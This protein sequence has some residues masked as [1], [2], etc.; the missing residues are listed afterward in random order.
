MRILFIG[1]V[2][3]RSG[4]EALE[5]YLPGLRRRYDV[6]VVIVNAENAAHGR[7]PTAK[8]CKELFSLGVDCITGG[9]H[10]WDQR[11]ILSYIHGEKRLLRPLNFP[12][13]SPGQGSYH[14]RLADG[15]TVLIV[16]VVG[17]YGMKPV[18]DPF[19]AA[20][21]LSRANPLGGAIH[22]LFVD[23][24]MEMTSEKTAFGHFM[25]GKASAVL[26]SHT[27][28]PTADARIL[29]GGTAYQSDVGMTGDYDSVIG[30][31]KEEPIQRFTRHMTLG[32]FVPAE[33][34]GTLC[35]A[36]VET[37]DRTGRARAIVPVREGGVL[38]ESL[39][40]L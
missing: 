2:M 37:D 29:P 23:A 38:S 12:K 21:A 15:R 24:H 9:D 14:H 22:A 3:G 35:G 28:V 19:A 10:I 20:E 39:P 1:D 5:A 30:S 18:D 16:H 32:H 6:D 4:R 11:E 13:D 7:G 8:I 36:V 17:R 34:P 31:K 40:A 26:G 27:H 33:G 25:D